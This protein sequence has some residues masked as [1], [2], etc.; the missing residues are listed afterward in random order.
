MRAPKSYPGPIMSRDFREWR[1]K[2]GYSSCTSDIQI[3]LAEAW[4]A[5]G[6]CAAKENTKLRDALEDMV[7]C[8]EAFNWD[9]AE[10]YNAREALSYTE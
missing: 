3:A 2:A 1:N 6:A 5:G 4:N 8:A 10:I 7:M 9:N